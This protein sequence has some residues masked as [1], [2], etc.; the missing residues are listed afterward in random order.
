MLMETNVPRMPTV[1]TSDAAPVP[2]VR[3]RGVSKSYHD[4]QRNHPVFDG[5]ELEIERGEFVVLLGRSGSGKSTLLN[6]ISGI[7]TPDSGEI[8]LNSVNLTELDETRRTLFRR[9]H[10]GFVFQAYNLIPTLTVLENLIL[11]LELNCFDRNS[12]SSRAQELL[13][14]LGLSDRGPDFP[15]QLSG[16]EQQRVTIARALIHSPDL[17]LADEPTGNLDRET[18]HEVLELLVS[19]LRR[20]GTTLIMATHSPE[21]INFA[22][23]SFSIRDF[24]LHEESTPSDPAN[25]A[26]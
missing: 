5:L 20:T 4:G 19:E 16:G 26:G 25:L 10:T 24:R 8:T 14:G 21:C 3:L 17:V 9:R 2:F 18:G 22:D 6:L 13:T 1:P 12:R 15:D 7:D 11:P 23:R